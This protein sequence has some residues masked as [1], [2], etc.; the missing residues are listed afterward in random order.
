MAGSAPRFTSRVMSGPLRRR[1]AVI[2]GCCDCGFGAGAKGV[3]TAAPAGGACVADGEQLSGEHLIGGVKQP[4]LGARH[5]TPVHS[6][7]IEWAAR[8]PGS[9]RRRRLYPSLPLDC[10]PLCQ[11]IEFTHEN[12]F[13]LNYYRPAI[14]QKFTLLKSLMNFHPPA[15]AIYRLLSALGSPF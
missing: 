6:H 11:P 7:P 1:G 12:I 9:A 13:S 14:R 15:Q 3:R 2:G 8:H 5:S 10:L 4:R